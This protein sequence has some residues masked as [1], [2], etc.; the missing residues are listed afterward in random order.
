MSEKTETP[1]LRSTWAVLTPD[2]DLATVAVT[3]DVYER[4]DGLFG[5]FEGHLLLAEHAFETDWPTWEIHP[6]GDE[7][8]VLLR[9][10]G[11]LVLREQGR[12]RTVA[13]EKPGAF[14][15][16]PRRTWHTARIA[17]PT[18]MLFVTPGAGTRNAEH[19]DDAA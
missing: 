15:R 18:A 11:E 17:E 3:A 7:L 10:R 9:G 1:D 12:D 2:R 14:V 13:L 4:L 5:G 19:P 6:D 16:V 8:I